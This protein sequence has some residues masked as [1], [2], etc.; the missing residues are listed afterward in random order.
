M[1]TG[2]GLSQTSAIVKI[3]ASAQGVR[4]RRLPAHTKELLILALSLLSSCRPRLLH[5]IGPSEWRNRLRIY[6]TA[7]VG[8]HGVRLENQPNRALSNDE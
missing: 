8:R 7:L 3:D 4:P 2:D 6:G 5:P 1:M